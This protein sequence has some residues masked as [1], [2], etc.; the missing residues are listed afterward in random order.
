MVRVSVLG[1]FVSMNM[2]AR[3]GEGYNHFQHALELSPGRTRK[4][5]KR[6]CYLLWA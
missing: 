2:S 3:Q 4:H 6:G 1:Y 5:G